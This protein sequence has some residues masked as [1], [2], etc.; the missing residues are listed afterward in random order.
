VGAGTYA[1]IATGS[2]GTDAIK[3]GLLYKPATVT[4]YG[5]YAILDSSVDPTFLDTKNRPVLA[6]T[7]ADSDGALLTVAVNHLKSKG[8]ACDDVG[9]PIDPLGQGNCN[10]VRTAAAQALAAWLATDPTGSGD[11]DALIIGDLNSY[12]HEDPITALLAAGYTDLVRIYQGEVAYTYVFDAQLG[13]L[14]Y[15][16]ANLSMLPQVTGLSTWH[17]NADEPDLIDYDTSFKL[18]AQDAIYEPN[19]YRSSDHDPVL[20][21]LSPSLPSACASAYPSHVELW[22][23]NHK[24]VGIEIL[25]L[26]DPTGGGL[27]VRI[28]R[29]FQDEPVDDGGAGSSAP[30]A[31]IGEGGTFE[32]RAERSGNGDGR[33][34]HVFFHVVDSNRSACIGEITVIVPH[35]SGKKAD[36][37]V[38]D[39]PLFD[40]TLVP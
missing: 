3:V 21:G 38:D 22:P 15:A 27:N 34:Y 36:A 5:A 31:V 33:F 18:P 17:I 24:F 16:L 1:Y 14:D 39:G 28:D 37:P 12:D 25:G 26:T 40:S 30:D 7:F 35:D 13:Y 29:I 32:V 9:D 23:A 4:P 2:I 10:G 19:A 6:Q 8:S 11:S 20:V